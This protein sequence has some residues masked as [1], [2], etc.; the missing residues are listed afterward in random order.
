M[1]DIKAMLDEVI[2]PVVNEILNIFDVTRAPVP[3]ELMLQRPREG[4][5]PQ[6]DIAEMSVSFLNLH[7]RYAPRMSTVRLLARNIARCAWGQERGLKVLFEDFEYINLF[8]RAIIMPRRLLEIVVD[9]DFDKITLS[10]RFEM[11]EEDTQAR[12]LDLGYDVE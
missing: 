12:L 6:V 11:P 1:T 3:V 5:W 7:D 10:G 2:D 4:T 8:A 9:E